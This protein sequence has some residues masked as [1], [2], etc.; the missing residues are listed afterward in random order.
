VTAEQRARILELCLSILATSR[1]RG[2]DTD[3]LFLAAP[4]DTSKRSLDVGILAIACLRAHPGELPTAYMPL[5]T[6]A[7]AQGWWK[8]A[9]L[10]H[11]RR[12]PEASQRE[13]L[14]AV[15]V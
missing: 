10:E 4:N 2:V 3:A 11:V 1:G 6:R 5:L 7:I 13:V 8:D 9:L 14:H 12:L 15:S